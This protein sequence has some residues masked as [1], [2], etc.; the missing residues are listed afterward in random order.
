MISTLK[1]TLEV[2][3][4]IDP[5]TGYP[6]LSRVDIETEPPDWAK[7]ITEGVSVREQERFVLEWI[8]AM[9][10]YEVAREQAVSREN[11]GDLPAGEYDVEFV[12]EQLD[13]AMSSISDPFVE[14]E[15]LEHYTSWY[16][17]IAKAT[18]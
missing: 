15:T 10:N 1:T 14:K 12:D 18:V 5:S 16:Q 4:G 11:R 8:T 7:D 3:K 9:H 13:D 6:I 17:Q 2:C